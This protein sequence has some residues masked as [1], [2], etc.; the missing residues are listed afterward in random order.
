VTTE[1]YFLNP[2]GIANIAEGVPVFVYRCL[3][4]QTIYLPRSALSFTDKAGSS[5]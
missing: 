1:D 2:V 5:G 4:D 3:D